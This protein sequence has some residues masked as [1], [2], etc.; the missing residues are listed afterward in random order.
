MP[1]LMEISSLSL[2]LL[3]CQQ[4]SIQSMQP[5]N[6][7][8]LSLWSFPKGQKLQNMFFFFS[9]NLFFILF[10]VVVCLFFDELFLAL[11]V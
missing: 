11:L 7:I 2:R 3:P 10:V 9:F 1:L 6:I 8:E 4:Q 5:L